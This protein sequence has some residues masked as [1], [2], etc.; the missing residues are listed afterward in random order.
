MKDDKACTVTQYQ[1]C[2]R[3]TIFRLVRVFFLL[4]VLFVVPSF[5]FCQNDPQYDEVTVYLKVQGIGGADI[6]ALIKDEV[7]YLSIS[8]VFTLL[9]IKNTASARLDSL[10]GFFINPQD[11]YLIDRIKKQ[12][13][14]QGKKIEL[15]P[16]DLIL[17]QT[18]LYMKASLY[19]E[20]FGLN[21]IFNMR[22]LSIL[23]T[24]KLELPLIREMKMEQMRNNL[25]RLN[26][27]IKTDST[28]GR[29]YPLF[30][31]GMADWA[32]SSTQQQGIEPNTQLSLN[33]GSVLAGGEMNLGLSYNQGTKFDLNQ[34]NY[35]WRYVNNETKVLRQVLIGKIGA[36]TISQLNGSLIGVQLTNTPTIYRR[37]FG[38]YTLRN[39]TEPGWLVELYV[40]NVLVDFVKADASGFYKFEVPL[41]Y[42]ISVLTVRMYGP[43]GE[44]RTRI[45]NANIPYNFLPP[46]ELEY[47]INAGVVENMPDAHLYRANLNYG[48]SRH[49]SIGGGYEYYSSSSVKNSL[50]YLG[51]SVMLLSDLLVAAEYTF[52]VQLK[53]SLSYRLPS[54]FQVDFNYTDY[55]KGQKKILGAPNQERGFSLSVPVQSKNFSL[56]TRASLS[57]IMYSDFKTTNSEFLISGNL[58]GVSSN[59]TTSLTFVDP[60]HITATS[61]VSVSFGLPGHFIMMPS[62]LYDFNHK[63]I[64]SYH[65]NLEKPLIGNG[66]LNISYDRNIA[67]KINSINV[68]LRYDFSFMQA[69]IASRISKN[70]NSFSQTARGSLLFDGKN[71]Y[72][73]SSSTSMVGRC[74]FTFLAYLDLNGNGKRDKN[75]PTISGLNVR[76]NGGRVVKSEKDSTIRVLDL[77][78][79][80]SYLVELDKNSFENISWQIKNK[81]L[82]VF[83]DPNQLKMIEVPISVMAEAAGTV[84]VK[85]KNGT[86]G[87]GRVYV[88]FYRNGKTLVG[89]TLTESDGYFSYMGLQPGKYV[90]RM[91]SVQL[92]KIK[93]VA[94]PDFKEF[95]VKESKDGDFVEGLDFTLQSTVKDSTEGTIPIVEPKQEKAA[96]KI[97]NYASTDIKKADTISGVVKKPVIEKQNL[98]EKKT[99][100][101]E[102]PA[103][104]KETQTTI[105]ES[106]IGGVKYSQSYLAKNKQDESNIAVSK[107]IP[108]N[109]KSD[110]SHVEIEKLQPM[111][112]TAGQTYSVRYGSYKSEN[113]ALLLQQKITTTT[114]KPA[115]LILEDG[116]YALWIEGFS[117][118]RDAREF[119][120]SLEKN[121]GKSNVNEKWVTPKN[122][123]SDS[124]SVI[125]NKNLATTVTKGKTINYGPWKIQNDLVV[126]ADSVTKIYAFEPKG[127][128]TRTIPT[129]VTQPRI[130][131]MVSTPI[132]KPLPLP[133]T[134]SSIIELNQ[135]NKITV[136]NGQQFSIQ[137]GDF[138]FDR[139]ALIALKK[140]STI[141]KLPVIIVIRKG[142]YNLVIDGFPTRKEAKLFV[143]QLKQMGY[144]GTVIKN[145]P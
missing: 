57:Q 145:N 117:T 134:K 121:E 98:A 86:R 37:S 136:I 133:V 43:W 6:P 35:L 80:T 91:D 128:K 69:S 124:A 73:G 139:S 127:S 5:C 67:T 12:I 143:D 34:Q 95:K 64:M 17:T 94:A 14:F 46:G 63:T 38:T 99:P 125:R 27:D 85:S 58:K 129:R 108:T 103:P 107:A 26:G 9:K 24:T 19:G 10:S 122:V 110:S 118:N 126:Y 20:V 76:V 36:Q 61:N 89:K 45:E 144:N 13:I 22:D 52:G 8:D 132:V 16:E 97:I 102:K 4:S 25:K 106:N 23:L 116:A 59:V 51:S 70:A 1:C 90:A 93:M 47:D 138:I 119:L 54:N 72:V 131:N 100:V 142:F 33:L 140:I 50:P 84:N 71:H 77:T 120:S 113:D 3:I 115:I 7:A 74:G 56:Y 82:S 62:V 135:N 53:S 42:G 87:L 44:V 123:N 28:I 78:P 83:A 101:V 30:K 130:S 112:S 81:T 96:E 79:Y 92:T 75:E 104:I 41:V 11:E 40:N 109:K 65:C 137:V 111:I 31:F 49:M 66:Y 55:A 2:M 48:I 141:T 32:V 88:N 18:N 21:C 105:K 29:R 15:K 60:K 39:I 68:G 114:G